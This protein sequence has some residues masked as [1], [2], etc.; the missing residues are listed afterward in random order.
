MRETERQSRDGSEGTG[1]PGGESHA[2]AAA[3]ARGADLL[4]R[5]GE[6]GARRR[7]HRG[8]G[9]GGGDGDAMLVGSRRWLWEGD[10]C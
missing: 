4:L 3:C 6:G 7:I 10:A 9:D 8:A 5:H 2:A 1:H